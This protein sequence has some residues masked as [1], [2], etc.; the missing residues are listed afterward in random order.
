MFR[1]VLFQNI[2]RCW[3]FAMIKEFGGWGSLYH[4]SSLIRTLTSNPFPALVCIHLY[5]FVTNQSESVH[6][7][8]CRGTA[9]IEVA[10]LRFDPVSLWFH[11]VSR[12]VTFITFSMY[13]ISLHELPR[14]EG[15]YCVFPVSYFCFVLFFK[16][17]AFMILFCQPGVCAIKKINVY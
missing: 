6:T 1:F 3:A 5:T 17:H 14:G 8:S 10:T 16:K 9:G 4:I 12:G 13:C 11:G 15:D 2:S 7:Y